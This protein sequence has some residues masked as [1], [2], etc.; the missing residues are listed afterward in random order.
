MRPK[1]ASNLVHKP[2]NKNLIQVGKKDTQVREEERGDQ[3]AYMSLNE[4]LIEPLMD[5]EIY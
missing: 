3:A 4:N 5:C 2:I 1:I